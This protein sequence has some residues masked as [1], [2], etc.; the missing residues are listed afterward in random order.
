MTHDDLSPA[1]PTTPD[2]GPEAPPADLVPPADPA[3][4]ADQVLPS[5][6]APPATRHLTGVD[7]E[8][9]AWWEAPLH[10]HE[11]VTGV[12]DHVLTLEDRDLGGIALLLCDTSARLVLPVFVEDF[13]VRTSP[14][15]RR[16][17]MDWVA[18]LCLQG[19]SDDVEVG[20]V[21][22]V[23][24]GS[25]HQAVAEHEWHTAVLDAVRRHG[26][27]LLGTY[28]VRGTVVR[29]LGGGAAAA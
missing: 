20:L 17:A 4:P 28:A 12:L 27:W 25:D 14:E 9:E 5:D 23:V 19:A 10:D 29:S 18:A 26:L 22:A 2:P 1:D 7:P 21:V 6:P 11:A 16:R 15:V 13:P 24:H 8:A 3:P